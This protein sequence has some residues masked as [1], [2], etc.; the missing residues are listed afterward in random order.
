[1]VDDAGRIAYAGVAAASPPARRARTLDL[2]GRTLLPGFFDCH[3]H[4]GLEG[5]MDGSFDEYPSVKVFNTAERMRV[6]LRAGITSA[7]DLGATE[8]GFRVAQERGLLDGP[9]LQVAIRLLSHTGGHMDQTNRSGVDIAALTGQAHEICD[10][11]DQARISA[12]RVIRDGADVIK[13]CATGGV[14]SPSDQPE[15]EGLTRE[16][17]AAV[18]DEARRHRN[19]PVAAHAQGAAGIKNAIRG[20]VNSI[21]HGYLIDD[22]GIDLALEHGTF[23]VPTMST[24]GNL[25]RGTPMPPHVKEKKKRVAEEAEK[26]IAAAIERG[27]K[28][29]I[30]TDAPVSRHGHNLE[31]LWRLVGLGMSPAAAI[32]AGTSASAE[33][34]GVLD[35]LGTVEEGKFADL[36]VCDGDP[37]VD[38]RVLDDPSNIRYVIQAGRI[39]AGSA[40]TSAPADV[41]V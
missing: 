8:A 40:A 22:E 2:A 41:A 37:L 17:I 38:I 15:D 21:E 18:V 4:F 35:T 25:E 24:F 9:R 19:K 31:E 12:R 27:V 26:R 30:G 6:T 11:V 33:L 28:I 5:W 13:L 23:L 36:I 1:V 14:S 16:E 7:R 29:A 34:C 10:T 3:V 20:G 32:V 39:V